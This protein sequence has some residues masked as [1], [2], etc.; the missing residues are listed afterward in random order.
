MKFL[1]LFFTQVFAQKTECITCSAS[2]V[3]GDG[4]VDGDASCF[5]GISFF[6]LTWVEKQNQGLLNLIQ[7]GVTFVGLKFQNFH[8]TMN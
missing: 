6:L 4:I 7:P 2:Y 1:F 8:G 5:E 3:D